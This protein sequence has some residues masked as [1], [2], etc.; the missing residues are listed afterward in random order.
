MTEF[1]KIMWGGI[2]SI[3]DC[4]NAGLDTILPK[5]SSFEK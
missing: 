4:L 1:S 3:V 2:S 5:K